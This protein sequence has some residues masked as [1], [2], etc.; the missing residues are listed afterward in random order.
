MSSLFGVLDLGWCLVSE[1]GG[2]FHSAFRSKMSLWDGWAY[3]AANFG[4]RALSLP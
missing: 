4:S 1:H 2:S 3:E